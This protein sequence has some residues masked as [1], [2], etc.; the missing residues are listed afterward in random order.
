MQT[1]GR[2]PAERQR[3]RQR[4]SLARGKERRGKVKRDT[5]PVV[6]G[7]KP[8][9]VIC[10]FLNVHV[11]CFTRQTTN[12][13]GQTISV[14]FLNT[15]WF[16]DQLFRGSSPST[17]SAALP[18]AEWFTQVPAN[19]KQQKPAQYRNSVPLCLENFYNGFYHWNICPGDFNM[20]S[21]RKYVG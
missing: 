16:S 20:M 8:V 1:P 18:G 19:D 14:P 2:P 6:R 3:G 13:S 10:P 5:G 9:A 17:S 21:P 12:H 7:T 15:W 11:K 4:S